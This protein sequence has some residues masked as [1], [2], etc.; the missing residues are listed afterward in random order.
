[1]F[2]LTPHLRPDDPHFLRNSMEDTLRN[3]RQKHLIALLLEPAS[4][5]EIG[6]RAGY[7]ACAFLS[8]CPQARYLGL[9]ADTD[10]HG[11]WPGAP[12]WARHHLR[13]A[14]PQAQTEVRIMDTSTLTALPTGPWH[15]IHVDGEHSFAGAL[16]DLTLAAL[17]N[18]RWILLDDMTHLEEVAKAA[19]TFLAHYRTWRGVVL[20]TVR[21]DLL[22][23]RTFT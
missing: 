17:A 11:G 20:P 18:P 16:R 10:T 21:G 15:L 4:I 19:N 3:Y 7:S 12:E 9:D 2:D 22:L 5:L 1:V 13:E 23:Q 6:V 14:F 8:A